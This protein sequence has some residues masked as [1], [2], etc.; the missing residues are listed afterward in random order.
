MSSQF[1]VIGRCGFARTCELVAHL[2]DESAGSYEKA[3][4]MLSQPSVADPSLIQIINYEEHRLSWLVYMAG[5]L[6]VFS[7]HVYI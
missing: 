4:S 3:L 1:A 2:F 6:V 5:K 7:S